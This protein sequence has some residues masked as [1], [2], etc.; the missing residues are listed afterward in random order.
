MENLIRRRVLWRL[1]WVCTVCL[2]PTKMT[3]GLHGLKQCHLGVLTSSAAFN[4]MANINFIGSYFYFTIIISEGNSLYKRQC[5]ICFRLC[6]FQCAISKLGRYWFKLLSIWLFEQIL[7][8]R[9]GVCLE[10]L[11][12]F[13]VQIILSL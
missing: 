11:Q 10:I 5:V 12:E 1:I 8:Q 6:I 13:S 4:L 2:C 3:L 9:Y 7:I